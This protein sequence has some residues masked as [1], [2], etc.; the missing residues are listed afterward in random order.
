MSQVKLSSVGHSAVSS[1]P[2][3]WQCQTLRP[4]PILLVLLLIREPAIQ[5]L[6]R[7]G[8]KGDLFWK[9]IKEK[10][11]QSK[12]WRKKSCCL[13][14]LT[15]D[16]VYWKKSTMFGLWVMFPA[17][18]MMQLKKDPL[19]SEG[20]TALLNRLFLSQGPGCG[21]CMLLILSLHIYLI[22]LTYSW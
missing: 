8:Q 3:L 9:S 12:V 18:I 4:L 6:G 20:C 15:T 14:A 21:G 7:G 11:T 10:V 1:P 16:N 5:G 19:S 17:E 13:S 2:T 22:D